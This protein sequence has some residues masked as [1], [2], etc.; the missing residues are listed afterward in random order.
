MSYCYNDACHARKQEITFNGKW[1][2][3]NELNTNIQLIRSAQHQSVL[4]IKQPCFSGQWLSYA[5][6]PKR[7]KNYPGF[8]LDDFLM[9]D[10]YFV[11]WCI[12]YY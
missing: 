6:I 3:I 5:K 4:K 7:H 11:L 9:L 2:Q 8:H 1:L 12:L 10:T